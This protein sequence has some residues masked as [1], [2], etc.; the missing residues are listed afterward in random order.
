M[1]LESHDE[2]IYNSSQGFWWSFAF[3]EDVLSI[4]THVFPDKLK[5]P[6]LSSSEISIFRQKH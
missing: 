5:S 3:R 1:H 4:E 2:S 6:D